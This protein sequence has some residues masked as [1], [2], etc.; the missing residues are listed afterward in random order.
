[1]LIRPTID[2]PW[3]K[4]LL[5]SDTSL[6]DDPPAGG[7][8][9]P[10]GDD[11]DK[12]GESGDPPPG[13]KDTPPGEG[14]PVSLELSAE[15]FNGIPEQFRKDGT[16]QVEALVKSWKDQQDHI[17]QS[18][19][20]RP[21]ENASDYSFEAGEDETLKE[22]MDKVLRPDEKTGEDPMVHA[23][24]DEAHKLGLSQDQFHGVLAFYANK[25]GPQMEP[26]IDP[27]AEQKK[28]GVNWERQ[29]NYVREV[30]KN[31]E[32]NGTLSDD[33]VGEMRLAGQ[34]AAGVRMLTALIKYGGGSTVI[35][36]LDQ[37]DKA[38]TREELQAEIRKITEAR[39]NGEI[40]EAVANRRFQ[41][42][43]AEKFSMT[44]S[45][46]SE[47][48]RAGPPLCSISRAAI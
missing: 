37:T 17:K 39:D 40:T 31:L 30:R 11:G 9:P 43:P 46:W 22:N 3:R 38:S 45:A 23:F 5:L 35:P 33:M 14:D 12:P 34:T 26:P 36:K 8:P 6:I 24:R 2:E 13:D 27:E 20:H 29:T 1:M 21:P 4:Y 44:T 10:G 7:D 48:A 18:G 28:L 16:V 32:A 25:Q 15:Q 42:V 47:R 41:A 19:N